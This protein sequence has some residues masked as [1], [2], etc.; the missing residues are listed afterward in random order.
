[1]TTYTITER[2]GC[3][4]VTGAVPARSFG[5][6]SNGMPRNAVLDPHAARL[7]GVTFAIGTRENLDTLI[8]DPQ[9]VAAARQRAELI[10]S[11]LSESAKEWLA[12]GQQGTSSLTLFQ[13]LTGKTLVDTESHPS[14]PADLGRCRQLLE[15]VPEF[16]ERL[17]ELVQ[18][19]T[20]WASLVQHWDSLCLLMDSEAP[21]WR[22]GTGGAP[23]T[24]ARMKELGC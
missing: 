6:L 18:V 8:N 9:V 23:N 3:R 24:Y 21:N 14:D 15:Q 22:N 2:G 16:R 7:L 10:G 12:L 19:S 1:M 11:G 4:L 13:R 5:V 17:H 20:Q